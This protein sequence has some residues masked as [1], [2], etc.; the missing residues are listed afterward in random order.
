MPHLPSLFA[1]LCREPVFGAAPQGPKPGFGNR[2]D[3]LHQI[4]V[5][6]RLEASVLVDGKIAPD[7]L[8]LFSKLCRPFSV[9]NNVASAGALACLSTL[10]SVSPLAFKLLVTI[11]SCGRPSIA[12]YTPGS[13]FSVTSGRW[14]SAASRACAWASRWSTSLG[15]FVL[16]PVF[17]ANRRGIG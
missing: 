10:R 14:S 1:G 15:C 5:F 17:A 12:R 8:D 2:A 16:P 4:G 3:A 13:L 9:A 7:I 6:R 11:T